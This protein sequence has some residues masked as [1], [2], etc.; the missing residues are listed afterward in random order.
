MKVT[1][2]PED[3]MIGV[4]GVFHKFDFIINSNIH[5]IQW[6]GNKGEIEYKNKA[7]EK[8]DDFTPYQSL[9]TERTASI[10]AEAQA[11]R[12]AAAAVEAVIEEAK[13]PQDRRRE[14]YPSI[15]D[16][17]EAMYEARQG[18]NTKLA[19]ID[20]AIAIINEKYPL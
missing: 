16:Q 10:D 7:N 6:D 17:L 11:E 12:D 9:L 5:A 20:A 8:F 1:I 4:D 15:Q 13:T 3:K 19:A 2:I 14:E 18:D